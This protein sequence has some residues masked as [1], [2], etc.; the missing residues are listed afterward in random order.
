[1]KKWI[2]RILL[3]MIIIIA[4]LIAGLSMLSGT[5]DAQKAGLEDAFGKALSATVTFGELEFFNIFPQFTIKV[6]EFRG[7]YDG[8]KSDIYADHISL[9]FDFIDLITKQKKINQFNVD[10]LSVG[11][12]DWFDQPI[13]NA[14]I[15]IEPLEQDKARLQINGQYGD[16]PIDISVAMEKKSS[17]PPSYMFSSENHFDLTIGKTE[18]HGVFIPDAPDNTVLHDMT[19]SRAGKNCTTLP[20]KNRFS[21]QAF[22]ENIFGETSESDLKNTDIDELCTSILRYG[23]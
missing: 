20:E 17:L 18:V 11:K 12:G 6:K 5:G 9:S 23:L 16:R 2:F 21:M 14:T 7:I 22:T 1:M 13:T 8:E 19:V 15:K 3:T 10:N 4:F